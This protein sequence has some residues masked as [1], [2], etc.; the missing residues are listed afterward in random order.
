MVG[1][2]YLAPEAW[3]RLHRVAGRVGDVDRRAGGPRRRQGQDQGGWTIVVAGLLVAGLLA[4]PAS[5]GPQSTPS[6]PWPTDEQTESL[7]ALRSY[8]QL[9][10]TLRGIEAASQ[11]AV[12][13]STAPRTS[14]TGRQIPVATIGHGPR[15]IM[16][17]AQQHGNEYVV[18][19][20]AVE[21]IRDLSSGSASSR[22][23]REALTV[24]VV[25]RVNVDGFDAPVQDASGN[26]PPW[27]EN[28]DPFCLSSCPAFY[29]AGR[30]YDINRY[31]S[32]LLDHPEDDPNTPAVDQNPVPE[33]VAMRLLFDQRRPEVVMDLHHQGSY[34]DADGDLITGSTFWPN[35]TG[36][37]AAIGRSA[38]FAQAVE[39]SKKVVATL[40]TRL[41]QYG[42]ANISR[43]PGTLPP[44]IARNAYGLL[45]AGSVLFELR[46][47]IGTKSNGYIAKTAYHAAKSVVEALADG[48]LFAADTAVADALPER[49]P[50]VDPPNE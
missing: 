15:G 45:G 49:G 11:G 26:T 34:V 21:L 40:V 8:E 41:D 33:S 2:G 42:F 47:D 27:R 9:W 22:A 44:G 48:S 16:V 43:Y 20:G 5:A 17:I 24:T 30:G 31:H 12:A 28:F 19:N 36:T 10:K 13:L 37:A 46:G 7:S 4:V 50:A 39:L 6:G 14:N 25:P 1:A 23:I 35:A 29:Q 18:S 32:Y 38:E 3:R